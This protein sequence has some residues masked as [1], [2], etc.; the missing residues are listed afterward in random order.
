MSKAL[1]ICV[2]VSQGNTRR[3]ADAMAP[4]L[5]AAVVAPEDVSVAELADYDLVGFGSGIYNQRL[6]ARL[7]DFVAAI[8][9]GAASGR[10]FVFGSS[11]FPPLLP[12]QLQ[13]HLVRAGFTV[14]GEFFCRGYDT[15]PPFGWFGGAKRNRPDDA[16]LAAARAFAQRL[17]D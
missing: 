13:R 11:G 17:V 1:L 3:V 12:K 10:A 5:G 7:R 15:S 14:A 16:D 6:H 9:D 2:S 8:P 4:V